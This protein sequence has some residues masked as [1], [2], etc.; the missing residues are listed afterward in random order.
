[1]LIAIAT[2]AA[3]LTGFILFLNPQKVNIAANRWLGMFMV[4]MG[5]ALLEIVMFEHDIINNSPALFE[6]VVLSRFLT[7]PF[8]YLAISYFTNLDQRFKS[9]NLR[10]FLPYTVFLIYRIPF[11]I[12]G[13]N[14]D[15]GSVE[16][17]AIILLTVLKV[18]LPLQTIIYWILCMRKLV[19]HSKNLKQFSSDTEGTALIWLR[20]FLLILAIVLL[21][22]LTLTFTN[23]R[24]IKEA[25]PLIYLAAMF[26]LGYFGLQ[27]KQ[28]FNYTAERRE[29]LK[30]VIVS[31]IDPGHVRQ[32]R[33]TEERLPELTE[34]LTE[35]MLT[36]KIYL[37]NDLSLPVLAGRLNATCNETSYLIN[38]KYGENFYSFI[39][40]YRVEEA[41]LLLLSDEYNKLNILGIAYQS[42]FN[43]K[44]TFNSAFKKHTGLSPTMFVK[45]PARQVAGI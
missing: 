42:G 19:L 1:M 8:L 4:T 2:G 24:L 28:I 13:K 44:T 3:F 31:V 36:D 45:Q 22:W 9:R 11:F 33:L 5:L 12:T 18:A 17:P 26:F 23:L 35:L 40:R 27:Q 29:E 34:K 38:E 30:E 39:N 14:F 37:E 25:T 10:H 15:L 16:G 21:V 20:N 43:S 41:K 32:K 7:A 6:M